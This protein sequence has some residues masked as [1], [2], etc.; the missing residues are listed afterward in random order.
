MGCDL[1]LDLSYL[2]RRANWVTPFSSLRLY[3]SV[4]SAAFSTPVF[5]PGVPDVSGFGWW[6]HRR[7]SLAYS[8]H[9]LL[10]APRGSSSESIP[11]QQRQS[12]NE[13]GR[14]G[15]TSL[16]ALVDDYAM[17]S[18]TSRL[19]PALPSTDVHSSSL[20]LGWASTEA[21]KRGEWRPCAWSLSPPC[22]VPSALA[23][24]HCESSDAIF[25]REKDLPSRGRR[26]KENLILISKM[27][28]SRPQRAAAAPDL[29]AKAR[30]SCPQPIAR[31][32]PTVRRAT[33][34]VSK[35]AARG[36]AQAS[37]T[38][39][40][41]GVLDL[42]YE[43]R[44]TLLEKAA[45]AI[46][47]VAT[48]AV[49]RRPLGIFL[50]CLSGLVAAA[51]ARYF[52]LERI[53]STRVYRE[54]EEMADENSRFSRCSS[55]KDY[56]VHYKVEQGGGESPGIVHMS[57]GFGANVFSWEEVQ[58]LLAQELGTTLIAHDTPAFGLTERPRNIDDFS[59]RKNAEISLD[60]VEK[61][62]QSS[63]GTTG[64][65]RYFMGHSMGCI[66]ASYAALGCKDQVRALILVAPAIRHKTKWSSPP[67]R[68]KPLPSLR[69]GRLTKRSALAKLAILAALSVVK[70][71]LLLLLRNL[72][73]SRAFWQRG[74]EAAFFNKSKVSAK[75]VDMYR[76]P[77]MVRRW[78]EGMINFVLAQ[79]G[80]YADL[81]DALVSLG[82]SGVRTLIIHGENDA[83]VPVRN[84][85]KLAAEIPNCVLE[86]IPECGHNPQEELPQS[87]VDIVS[88]FW[89][90]L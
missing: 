39:T 46:V 43:P 66:S 11:S 12:P 13:R 38:S 25:S 37:A 81:Q 84:S 21:A 20:A 9:K 40:S 7:L 52:L 45:C 80:T 88:R 82:A 70:P 33:A 77:K 14:A 19:G 87:F 15:A 83:I 2:L 48:S 23:R 32:H 8:S 56:A 89:K 6:S 72:V 55:L 22:S 61:F 76:R 75:T 29:V 47:G 69:S 42:D 57:H 79:L 50:S 59:L 60:L 64:L 31:G 58:K 65:N 30:R 54:P 35:R 27:V 44:L 4:N 63:G 1:T 34:S 85:V 41:G 18:T 17:A 53:W 90:S 49:G 3:S 74:L 86:V 68:G 16:P 28:L 36:V 10:D 5:P 62:T 78:D 24:L 67:G 73:R 26:L 51:V 71:L